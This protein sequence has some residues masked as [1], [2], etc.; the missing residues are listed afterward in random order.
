M[1]KLQEFWNALLNEL[2]NGLFYFTGPMEMIAAVIDIVV[3][4][5][6]VYHLLRLI[7]NTQAWQLM[8]GI[9]AVVILMIIGNFIGLKTINYV[10]VNSASVLA[11]ALVV[12]F[13]PELRK[14]LES[15]GR[16]SSKLFVTETP[17]DVS[18][19]KQIVESI[20]VACDKMASENTGALL[21]IER[22][23]K[24]SDLLE[25]GAVVVDADL[26]STMLRQIF[27]HNSPMHDG[28]VI[29]REGRIYATRVHVPLGESYHLKR[30]LG[31]RHRAAIGASEIGDAISVVC[32][33]EHGTISIA[34][35]GRLYTLDDAD[36]LR[37]ILNRM[38]NPNSAS[39]ASLP[40]K[41]RKILRIDKTENASEESNKSKLTEET[42]REIE[43]LDESMGTTKVESE[44]L[45]VTSRPHR[46]KASLIS[47]AVVVA[48]ALWLYVRVTT[49]PVIQKTYTVPLQTVGIE[50]LYNRQL[51]YYMG[52]SE[53][54]VTIKGREEM[55]NSLQPNHI[56][57]LVDF[58]SIKEVGT[59]S[60]A[61]EIR[62]ESVRHYAYTAVKEPS[63]I[64]VMINKMSNNTNNE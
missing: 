45:E 23:T 55:L 19:T 29:I 64:S 43:S 6:V 9:I 18:L 60:L 49:N 57:A 27:Y 14:T 13:Q 3:T 24:L 58:S 11:I 59:F 42:L 16:R 17:S 26:T 41:I 34:V 33:E 61:T 37:L 39:N 40:R 10:L 1:V 47:T 7:S 25:S 22:E 44:T 31:T 21:I 4:T 32:S 12:V 36:S 8:K 30:E 48:L 46:R 35:H 51:D 15:V 62:I 28:A 2:Q 54:T 52:Q 56:D 38:L 63:Y 5:L 53:I 50:N 20:V